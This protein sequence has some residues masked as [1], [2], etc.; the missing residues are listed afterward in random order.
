MENVLKNFIGIAWPI[1]LYRSYTNA[2]VVIMFF[3]LFFQVD[4][5]PLLQ[6]QREKRRL[7][8]EECPSD[9]IDFD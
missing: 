2:P 8:L 9:A 6:K 4:P 5:F 3:S 7:F 1:D